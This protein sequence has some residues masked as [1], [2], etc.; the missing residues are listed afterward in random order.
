MYIEEYGPPVFGALL[1]ASH[2]RA[3][4]TYMVKRCIHGKP[5]ETAGRKAKGTKASKVR[6]V[7]SA[8]LLTD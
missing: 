2:S 5:P 1:R 6:D 4:L 3:K 7:M 8:W